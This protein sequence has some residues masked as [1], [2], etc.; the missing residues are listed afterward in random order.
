MIFEI[1]SFVTLV[2]LRSRCQE[3]IRSARNLLGEIPVK[4]KGVKGQELAE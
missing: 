1:P 2:P 3:R 4:D